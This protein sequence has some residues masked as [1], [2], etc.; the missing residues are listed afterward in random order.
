[1]SAKAIFSEIEMDDVLETVERFAASS[2]EGD[3]I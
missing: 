1:M 2:F 3:E